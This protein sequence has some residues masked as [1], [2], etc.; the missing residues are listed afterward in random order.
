MSRYFRDPVTGEEIPITGM[1]TRAEI[2]DVAESSEVD[3]AD[4]TATFNSS[5]TTDADANIWTSVTKLSSGEDHKSIFAK[6][7]QMF[8]NVRWLY[9]NLSTLQTTVA[10]LQTLANSNKNRL[11]GNYAYYYT[12]GGSSESFSS[13]SY[14]TWQVRTNC[15]AG[16]Y[17]IMLSIVVESSANRGMRDSYIYVEGDREERFYRNDGGGSLDTSYCF[18][19]YAVQNALLQFKTNPYFTGNTFFTGRWEMYRISR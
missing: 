7:S 2:I 16:W 19:G 3:T 4:N 11:D 18:I 13:G 14:K 15:V 8:K 1:P 9:K 12:F 5:D 6:M 10:N 17:V